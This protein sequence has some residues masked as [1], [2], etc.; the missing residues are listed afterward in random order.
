[1]CIFPS[2]NDVLFFNAFIM[3]FLWHYRM[4]TDHEVT[5]V[6]DSMMEFYVNFKGP[7]DSMFLYSFSVYFPRYSYLGGI[8]EFG[9]IPFL[10]VCI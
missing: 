9:T 6:N 3:V 4:M 7:K 5:L 8:E 1:M 10:Y 2:S